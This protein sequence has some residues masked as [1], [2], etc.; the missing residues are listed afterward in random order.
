MI[1]KEVNIE[2][3]AGIKNI[4]NSYQSDFDYGIGRDAGYVYG[5]MAP[6]TIY[7]GIKFKM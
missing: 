6:Q 1:N 5:P 3:F 4:L 2:F 7:A